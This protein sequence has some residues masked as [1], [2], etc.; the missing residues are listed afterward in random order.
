LRNLVLLANK[1]HQRPQADDGIFVDWLSDGA[2]TMA[3]QI[4]G[5][6]WIA[7]PGQGSSEREHSAGVPGREMQED[8]RRPGFRRCGYGPHEHLLRF[9]IASLKVNEK[10]LFA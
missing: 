10:S 7:S 8:Q 5:V 1:A 9:A 4:D 6:A 2:L 3:Q